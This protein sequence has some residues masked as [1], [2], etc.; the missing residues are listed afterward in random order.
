MIHTPTIEFLEA[1]ESYVKQSVTGV[2]PGKSL[3]WCEPP[4]IGVVIFV[5]RFLSKFRGGTKQN[6]WY[7]FVAYR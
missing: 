6:E 5:C 1:F 4:L 3:P 7:Q 2:A